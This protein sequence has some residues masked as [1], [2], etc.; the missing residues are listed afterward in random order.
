M[1]ALLFTMLLAILPFQLMTG[2]DRK[3]SQVDLKGLFND[4]LQKS[5][6][7]ES[8]IPI[9]VAFSDSES[10]FIR[11][12]VPITNINITLYKDG[13]LI[14]QNL[15]S[16]NFG[17]VESVDLTFWGAGGYS[18]VMTTPRGTFIQGDFQLEE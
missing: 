3:L 18:L 9:K 2:A 15:L 11:F 17:D 5:A 16:V 13:V 7:E 8:Y 12:E 14:L 10:L 1:K 4:K 6:G